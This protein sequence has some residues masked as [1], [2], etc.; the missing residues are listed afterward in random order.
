[1][2]IKRG[3][4][5]AVCISTQ[6][7]MRKSPVESAEIVENHGIRADAHAGT[8]KRQ[9]SLLCMGSIDKMRRKGADVGPGD[10]AENL[11][12]EGLAPTD[13]DCGVRLRLARGPILEITQIG[14]KCHSACEIA[15]QVGDC[16]MPREGLFSGVLHGGDV[17]P[18][19]WIEVDCDG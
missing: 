15:R 2:P 9:V 19:D 10:F 12:V 13:F 7:G 3:T 6:K 16:V 4:V 1:M 18:G 17:Q 14:K 8:E 11:T 5:V